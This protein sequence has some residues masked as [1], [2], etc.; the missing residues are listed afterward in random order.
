MHEHRAQADNCL[1]DAGRGRGI[2]LDGGGQAMGGAVVLD[3]DQKAGIAER[4][5]HGA[6]C[7]ANERMVMPA[8]SSA[9][10]TARADWAAPGLSPW[11]HRES[12]MTASQ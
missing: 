4:G 2:D 8:A 9:A 1:D 3:V 6:H 7:V 5:D 12:A 10:R 11:T